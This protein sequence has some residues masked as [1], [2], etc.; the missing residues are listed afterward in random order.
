MRSWRS[1]RGES[2]ARTC[3]PPWQRRT[4]IAELL[5]E[6]AEWP[7]MLPSR[8]SGEFVFDMVRRRASTGATNSQGEDAF[9]G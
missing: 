2:P 5:H 3:A 8:R 4:L 9:G 6:P 7:D 1:A